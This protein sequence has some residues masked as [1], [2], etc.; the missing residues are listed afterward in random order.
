[1]I[2]DFK[3]IYPPFFDAGGIGG[4]I[5]KYN[6]EGDVIWEVMWAN[7]QYQQHHYAFQPEIVRRF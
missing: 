2:I 5:Q 3:N 1:M 4:I 6:W 7:N